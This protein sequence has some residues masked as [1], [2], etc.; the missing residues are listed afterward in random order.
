MKGS[1]VQIAPI[2]CNLS[3]LT[4]FTTVSDLEHPETILDQHEPF[5]LQVMVEFGGPGAIALMPLSLCIKVSFFAEP[6]GLGSKLELGDSL[7]DTSARTFTYTPTLTIATPA[8][9]GLVAEGIYQVTAV[10]HVGAL[11]SP[12]LIIGFIDGLIIQIYD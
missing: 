4:V 10:L 5:S 12:A 3:H 7:V 11:N 9:V 6:C 1:H 2:N 8:S